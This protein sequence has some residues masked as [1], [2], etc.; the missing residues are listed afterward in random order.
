MSE[1]TI[2][3]LETM[4]EQLNQLEST[5]HNLRSDVLD[6]IKLKRHID[7]GNEPDEEIELMKSD[8]NELQEEI[9]K[10]ILKL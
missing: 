9:T 3:E 5:A 2:E 1:Y 4:N 10:Q 8:L 7:I 6:A